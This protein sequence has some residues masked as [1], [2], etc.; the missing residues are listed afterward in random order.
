MSGMFPNLL[1]HSAFS[2]NKVGFPLGQDHAF[3]LSVLLGQLSRV[4]CSP[5]L[6][7][8]TQDLEG[9][10][11]PT[12]LS[13]HTR[14]APNSSSTSSS[15]WAPTCPGSGADSQEA[16]AP[17]RRLSSSVFLGRGQGTGSKLP[18][19]ALRVQ[20]LPRRWRNLAR[21]RG[22]PEVQ[23]AEGPG[24]VLVSSP[25]PGPSHGPGPAASSPRTERVAPKSSPDR[26]APVCEEA[27]RATVHP[28]TR[29]EGLLG[30]RMG[31]K[32]F[33]ALLN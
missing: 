15:N 4:G 31:T 13:A 30:R 5:E 12:C 10:Q 14:P 17:G 25:A 2:T 11:T 3:P 28:A 32:T 6:T 19:L 21:E 7:Q 18:P 29:Q 8:P 22:P 26:L 23:S 20:W 9:V 1:Q 33:T 16:T 27:C 24:H